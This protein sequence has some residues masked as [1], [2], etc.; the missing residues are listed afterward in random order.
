MAD[1]L[2]RLMIALFAGLLATGVGADQPPLWK[3][4]NAKGQVVLFG[5]FHLLPPGL[6]WRTPALE[7][8]LEEAQVIVFETAP[9]SAQKEEATRALIGKHGTLPAGQSLRA[10]LPE[11]VYADFERVAADLQMS[12]AGLDR[13]RPWLAAAV[14]GVQ[15][16]TVRG[17]DPNRGVEAQLAEWARAKGKRLAELETNEAQM[18]VFAGLTRRQ[19]VDLFAASV[20]Q[21]REIPGRLDAILAAYREGDLAGLDKGLN[22]GYEGLPALR[23]QVLRDRHDKWLPRIEKMLADGRPHLIIVGAAHLVG[24][25]GV[26]ALLRARGHKLAG[27]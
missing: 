8:A 1:A 2:R 13:M 24:P 4:G 25:D 16:M 20:R 12:P 7:R 19:E 21:I 23:R 14:L 9:A 11:K 10:I 5:S 18:K 26:V 17:Y 3:A 15:F 6:Q 22:A 27:P